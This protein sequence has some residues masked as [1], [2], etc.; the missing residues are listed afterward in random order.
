[1]STFIS[2]QIIKQASISLAL[3]QAKYRAYFINTSLYLAFKADTDL[4]L[5]TTFTAQYPNGY[6]ACIVSA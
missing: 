2:Q 6:G 4:I 3:G 5:T 1:M